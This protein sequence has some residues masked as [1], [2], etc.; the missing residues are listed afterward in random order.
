M[1]VSPELTKDG[2]IDC[3]LEHVLVAVTHTIL[4]YNWGPADPRYTIRINGLDFQVRQNLQDFLN[5]ARAALSERPLWVDAICIDQEN[6][7]ERNHQ[8]RLMGTIYGKAQSV[9]VWLGCANED[10]RNLFEFLSGRDPTRSHFIR[11]EQIQRKV[12]N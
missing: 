6:I 1:T 8:V 9:I 3:R 2:L 12:Q 11:K 5:I 10:L 4:S 7:A